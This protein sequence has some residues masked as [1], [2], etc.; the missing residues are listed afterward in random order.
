MSSE[1]ARDDPGSPQPIRPAGGPAPSPLRPATWRHR[2]EY[3]ALRLV[4]ALVRVLPE[5]IGLG[6]GAVLGWVAGTVFRVR[7]A[8][9]DSNLTIAF[10]ERSKAWRARVA[11]ASYAHLGRETAALLRNAM[12]DPEWTRKWVERRSRLADGVAEDTFAWAAERARNGQGTVAVTGHLGNWEVGGSALALRGL[13]LTAVA[14]GQANPLVDR[15][16]KETRHRLGIDVVGKSRAPTRVGA[17]LDSGRVV[18][19]VAD[20]NARRAGVRVD[21]FGRS[22]S[23]ARGAA[24]FAIRTGAPVILGVA[25]REP[26]WPQRYRVHLERV[27]WTP[28]GDLDTD[29]RRLTEA[30]T[31][32]LE[33]HVRAAPEQY[34]WQHKRW[35]E[36]RRSRSAPEEPPSGVPVLPG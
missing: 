21:F 27:E 22:A 32:A 4:T 11:R 33:R 23:T 24:L 3:A 5:R 16:L 2:L 29:V 18:A 25:L 19:I 6:A 17:A 8:V 26:G 9:V 14:V 35:R 10:P 31:A 7:R 15:R 34:L 36:P 30:H 1:P 12:S 13:P 20:Q 28:S